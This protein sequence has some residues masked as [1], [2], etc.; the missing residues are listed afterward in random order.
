MLQFIKVEIVRVDIKA[1][2]FEKTEDFVAEETPIHVFI[3]RKHYVTIF[4]TPRDVRELVVGNLLSEG[5]IKAAGEIDR[6]SVKESGVCHVTLKSTANI[7][8]RLKLAQQLYRVIPS[9]CGGQ[10]QP[11]ALRRIRKVDSKLTVRAET[12]QRCVQNLNV[13]S[14]TYRK[15]HGVHAAAIYSGDGALL[16]FAEDVGRHNAVDKAIGKCA[17]KGENFSQ[18]L[19]ALSGRLTA[20]ITLKAARVGI[21]IVAS[22][23]AALNSG[24][25]IARKAN[26]TLLGLVRGNHMNIYTVPERILS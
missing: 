22:M 23:T 10:R 26:L 2:K 19:L 4:C 9:A 3:N 17:L 24:I 7:E 16:S 25:E 6:V 5:I 13:M 15:T 18:C 12:V 20:D 1:L 21:P 8:S 14:E 11:L